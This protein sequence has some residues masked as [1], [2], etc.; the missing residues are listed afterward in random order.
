[1]N[2]FESISLILLAYNEA[3]TIEKE[4]DE[5]HTHILD[6]ISGSECI[7]AEDGSTDGT[8]TILQRLASEGKIIHLHSTQ[9]R[10][11]KTALIDALR[12]AHHPYIFFSDTG[13]KH[14][15]QDF[16]KLYALRH[17]YDV[18]VGKKITRHDPFYRH[19]LTYG[20]NLF[21]RTYFRIPGV[22]DADSGF[23]LLNKNVRDVLVNMN[24]LFKDLVASE[25]ILRLIAKGFSYHE[26]PIGYRGRK[27]VSRGLPPKKILKVIY[28]TLRT[29]PIL[30]HELHRLQ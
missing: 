4:I 10:G 15:P 6:K 14:H 8:S 13:Y 17:E 2:Q 11:Y 5:F 25:M 16:W 26:V 27:G 3:A 22:Y 9:R 19:I 28:R 1:M 23:R 20:Y 12:T 24:L 21:L 30:K 7:V 18:I 29:A